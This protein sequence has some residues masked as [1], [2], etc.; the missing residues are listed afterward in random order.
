MPIFFDNEQ[1]TWALKD[2]SKEELDFLIE[3]GKEQFIANFAGALFK[4]MMPSQD[5]AILA[6]TDKNQMG[7]A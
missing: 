5:E 4:H 1:K 3:L 7:Q 2:S 6:A